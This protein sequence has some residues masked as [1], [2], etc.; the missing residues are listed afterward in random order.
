MKDADAD[1]VLAGHTHLPLDR[2]VGGIRLV[3]PGS[4][5]NP[6]PPDLQASYVIL[7]ADENRYE[8][9]NRRVGYDRW[10]FRCQRVEV[11]GE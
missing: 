9:S 8:T 4:I 5:S 1:L 3:N 10:E 11:T 6:F 7:E 2:T